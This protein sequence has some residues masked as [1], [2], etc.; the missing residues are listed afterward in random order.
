MIMGRR[1]GPWGFASMDRAKQK[2]IASKGGIAAHKKG[3]AHEW[4]AEEA[5][6]AGKKGG[7]ASRGGRGKPRTVPV[8]TS[9]NPPAGWEECGQ[10][11]CYHPAGF[12]GDCRDDANRWPSSITAPTVAP[13]SDGKPPV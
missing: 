2:A 10:C 11:S 4:T 8:H 12:M 7:G 1:P 5:R 6:A 13:E 9:E 3:T